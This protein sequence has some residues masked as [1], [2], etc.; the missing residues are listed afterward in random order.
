MQMA[1][2]LSEQ[3]NQS[4]MRAEK[5]VLGSNNYSFVMNV[6]GFSL[7]RI[8]VSHTEAICGVVQAQYILTVKR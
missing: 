2:A 1:V 6:F 8:L 7:L 5:K 3:P 4:D